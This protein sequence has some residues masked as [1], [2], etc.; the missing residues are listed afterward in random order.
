VNLI[1]E[2]TRSILRSLIAASEGLK[3]K[4]AICDIPWISKDDEQKL[5]K[6]IF[7][8][9]SELFSSQNGVFFCAS[10]GPAS[11][12]NSLFLGHKLDDCQEQLSCL[13]SDRPSV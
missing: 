13:D 7:R 12:G 11:G 2:P 10:F 9:D 5:Q 8:R 6:F 1:R 4:D 3:K